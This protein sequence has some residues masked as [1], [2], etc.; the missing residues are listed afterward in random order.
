ML[1]LLVKIIADE[2]FC[3]IHVINLKRA[4]GFDIEKS[5][6]IDFA[7]NNL[8][9]ALFQYGPRELTEDEKEEIRDTIRARYPEISEDLSDEELDEMGLEGAEALSDV[10]NEV[11]NTY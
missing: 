10:Y 11:M 4:F 2:D 5:K 6:E 1:T 3:S 9:E 7:Y 8:K